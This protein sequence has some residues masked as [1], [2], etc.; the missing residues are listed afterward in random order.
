M[1]YTVY[2]KYVYIQHIHIYVIN[3]IIAVY[4]FEGSKTFEI[5]QAVNVLNKK[6][7]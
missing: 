7:S 2:C 5:M 4:E 1:S 3:T 6:P